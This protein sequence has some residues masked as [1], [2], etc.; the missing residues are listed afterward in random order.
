MF[1]SFLPFFRAI[2]SGMHY[3]I[4]VWMGFPLYF[5]LRQMSFKVPLASK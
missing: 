3:Y 5:S 2:C 1:I 4:L